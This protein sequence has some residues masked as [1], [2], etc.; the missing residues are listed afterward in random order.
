MM[1]KTTAELLLLPTWKWQSQQKLNAF[2]SKNINGPVK[3]SHLTALF[4]T[5]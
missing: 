5:G 1:N 3:M 2:I 4:L